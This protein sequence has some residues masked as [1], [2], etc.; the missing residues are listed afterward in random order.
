MLESSCSFIIIVASGL[1]SLDKFTPCS[2]T[3]I[4]V[5]KDQRI[6]RLHS[7]LV[8]TFPLSALV[9]SSTM[10]R[11]I[12]LLKLLQSL[13]FPL[14]NQ[15][16]FKHRHRCHSPHATC[17]LTGWSLL[18]S[19]HLLYSMSRFMRLLFQIKTMKIKKSCCGCLTRFK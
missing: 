19:H 3:L 13:G 6:M 9:H 11:C 16:F 2:Q 10:T 4:E 15:S 1:A 8:Q 17:S 7:H 18:H 5:S 12:I 14:Y